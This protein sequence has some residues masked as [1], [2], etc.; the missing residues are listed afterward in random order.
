VAT[1][2]L[3]RVISAASGIFVAVGQESLALSSTIMVF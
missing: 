3:I 1:I 2:A